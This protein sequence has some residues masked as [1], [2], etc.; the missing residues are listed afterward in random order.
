MYLAKLNT[1][2]LG[3]K[4]PITVP[5]TVK[6]TCL[7]SQ[8]MIKSLEFE[9]QTPDSD[10]MVATLKLEQELLDE[11]VKFL[12]T[13]LKLSEE[14]MDKVLDHIDFK[15]LA[16]YTSYVCQRIKGMSEGSYRKLVEELKKT[17]DEG[18]EEPSSAKSTN[19]NKK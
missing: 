15:D 16:N 4:K 14:Q 6:N 11:Q 10:D 12:R 17:P 9:D 3:L 18:T 1:K 8:I 2:P 19:S 5:A 7:A 13:V